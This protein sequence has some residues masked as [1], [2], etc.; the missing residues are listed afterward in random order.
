MCSLVF[1][2]QPIDFYWETKKI[3]FDCFKLLGANGSLFLEETSKAGHWLRLSQ[4]VMDYLGMKG[5]LKV[6][7]RVGSHNSV[8]AEPGIEMN[9]GRK[10]TKIPFGADE[11]TYLSAL[12]KILGK[13]VNPKELLYR[14]HDYGAPTISIDGERLVYRVWRDGRMVVVVGDLKG[15]IFWKWGFPLEEGEIPADPSI[16]PNG[17]I[18]CFL[19]EHPSSTYKLYIKDLSKNRFY[20]HNIPLPDTKNVYLYNTPFLYPSDKF[21]LCGIACY[22]FQ[23]K[24]DDHYVKLY[25][26]EMDK[27]VYALNE[28]LHGILNFLWSPDQQKLLIA[29]ENRRE[30][31]FKYYKDLWVVDVPRKKLYRFKLLP[32][33]YTFAWDNNSRG[34]FLATKGKSRGEIFYL[35]IKG[36]KAFKVYKCNEGLEI[37]SLQN[38]G[39]LLLKKGATKVLFFAKGRVV[40]EV[41][42]FFHKYIENTP[43]LPGVCCCV[44]WISRGC[45]VIVGPFPTNCIEIG[46]VN[47]PIFTKHQIFVYSNYIVGDIIRINRILLSE[48]NWQCVKEILAKNTPIYFDIHPTEGVALLNS[49]YGGCAKLAL[50]SIQSTME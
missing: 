30:D 16:S 36:K 47:E 3:T 32:A 38:D 13:K 23:D 27:M 14:L 34:I 12:L 25:F 15:K 40:K 50:F 28:K 39:T 21:V 24:I 18:A 26:Y 20:K 9:Y 22:D 44:E 29:F 17:K 19:Y 2:T 48:K 6:K 33:H 11:F 41:K 7:W 49:L 37:F 45:Y 43:A 31:W 35:P 10:Q 5:R 42:A 4:S 1:A 46:V 8:T